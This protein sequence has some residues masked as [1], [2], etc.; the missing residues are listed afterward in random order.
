VKNYIDQPLGPPSILPPPGGGVGN[1]IEMIGSLK[2]MVAR[3]MKQCVSTEDIDDIECHIK[4][5]LSSF[6]SFDIA[7]RNTDTKPTWLTSYNFMCLINVPKMIQEFGPVRNLWEGG[8]QGEKIIG[9]L[10]PLWSY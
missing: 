6:E 8:G 9:L 7:M 5:F 4:L 3:I 2:A 10:K 1:I